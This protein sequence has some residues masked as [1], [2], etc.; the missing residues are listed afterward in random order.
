MFIKLTSA[1]TKSDAYFNVEHIVYVTKSA[2]GNGALIWDVTDIADKGP[3]FES[4]QS[5]DAVMGLIR[6][7]TTDDTYNLRREGSAED[8][9]RLEK[10]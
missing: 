9:N 6:A 8:L 10:Q 5:L 1:A 2:K 4:V 3:A 7:A